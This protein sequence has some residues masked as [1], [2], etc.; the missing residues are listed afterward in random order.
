MLRPEVARRNGAGFLARLD[1]AAIFGQIRGDLLAEFAVNEAGR[2]GVTI[3]VQLVIVRV[4]DPTEQTFSQPRVTGDKCARAGQ[5]GRPGVRAGEVTG[6][7][8]GGLNVRVILKRHRLSPYE[9]IRR[10]A[11][12]RVS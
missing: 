12:K 9:A 7:G 8:D 4:V 10:E 6:D 1:Q 11:L 5:K 2:D 3:V